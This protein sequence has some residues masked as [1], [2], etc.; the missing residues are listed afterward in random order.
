MMSEAA[1]ARIRDMQQNLADR[2]ATVRTREEL[3]M[4]RAMWGDLQ[5][6][7]DADG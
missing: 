1:S 7:L 4:L 3:V 5:G 2:A 6:I